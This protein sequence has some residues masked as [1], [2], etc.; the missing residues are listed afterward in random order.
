MLNINILFFTIITLISCSAQTYPLNTDYETIPDNSYLK[1]I[2][3]ELLPYIGVY[4]SHFNNNEI[5][6]FITKVDKKFE[7]SINK[8]YFMDILSVKY[9][10]KDTLG[11]IL[12]DTQTGLTNRNIIESMGTNPEKGIVYLSYLGTNCNV[13]WGKIILK[14]INSN[15]ISWSYYPNSSVLTDAN[16]P[17]NP[18]VTVYLPVVEN[19]IFTKE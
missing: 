9:V 19:L 13:G 18:D 1:D 2:N 6:L 4:K 8:K 17:G 10:I 11:R 15:Q 16:C 12:Q 14:K 7:N 5:S 3:N